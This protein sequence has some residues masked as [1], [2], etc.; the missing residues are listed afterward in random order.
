MYENVVHGWNQWDFDLGDK[1]DLQN[2]VEERVRNVK[3][4]IM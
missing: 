3:E 1:C 2:G 4:S